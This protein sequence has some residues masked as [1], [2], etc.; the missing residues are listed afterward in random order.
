MKQPI[1]KAQLAR[2]WGVSKPYLTKLAKKGLP[3]FYTELE[4]LEWRDKH[5]QK[6]H[7]FLP[8]Q[9]KTPLI[10]EPEKPEPKPRENPQEQP[11]EEER[12]LTDVEQADKAVQMAYRLFE[13]ACESRDDRLIQSRTKIWGEVQKQ[14]NVVKTEALERKMREGRALDIDIALNLVMNEMQEVRRR[15]TGL[16]ADNANACNPD[17][18]DLARLVINEAVDAIFESMESSVERLG[19]EMESEAKKNADRGDN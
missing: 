13:E 9:P 10:E 6:G 19:I 12:Q 16:G 3:P 14:A 5:I 18:P 11:L 2:L 17:N 1:T 8:E 7:K 4:A 15:L